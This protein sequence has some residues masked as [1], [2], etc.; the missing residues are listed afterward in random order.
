MSDRGPL[1]SLLAAACMVM[2]ALPA[3][4][5]RAEKEVDEYMD[6]SLETLLRL[7]VTSVTGAAVPWFRNPAAVYMLSSEDIRRTGHQTLAEVFRVVPGMH[8]ARIDAR[9]WAITARGFNNQFAKNLLVL[10]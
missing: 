6:M 2:V 7:D 4:A 5:D 10:T 8:V 9:Q 1:R 3:R